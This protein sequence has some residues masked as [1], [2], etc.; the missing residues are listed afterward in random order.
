MDASDLGLVAV[1]A[2]LLKAGAATKIALPDG[3]TALALARQN[4]HAAVIALL[5]KCGS[6]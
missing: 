4:G 5:E 3:R 1:V 2:E 6:C